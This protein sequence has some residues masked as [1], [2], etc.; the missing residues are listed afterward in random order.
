MLTGNNV[1]YNTEW[2][3]SRMVQNVEKLGGDLQQDESQGFTIK[4]MYY[5]LC[6]MQ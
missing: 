6:K 1:E 5:L 3:I 2:D 4:L